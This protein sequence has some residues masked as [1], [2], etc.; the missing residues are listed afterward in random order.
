MGGVA[1]G[2]QGK[3][4]VMRW[5]CH[6]F[7]VYFSWAYTHVITIQIIISGGKSATCGMLGP[8]LG[9]TIE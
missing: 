9:N 4:V 6:T 7:H 8:S 1:E 2:V 3:H 5:C